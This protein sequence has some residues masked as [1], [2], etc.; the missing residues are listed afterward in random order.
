MVS[1]ERK[2]RTMSEELYRTWTEIDKRMFGDRY[3]AG[4]TAGDI[5]ASIPVADYLL[6]G[7]LGDI[8]VISRHHKKPF[9]PLA[10]VRSNARAKAKRKQKAKRA[11][12]RR[13]EQKSQAGGKKPATDLQRRTAVTRTIDG[14]TSPLKKRCAQNGVAAL[15]EA[16]NRRLAILAGAHNKNPEQIL[17]ALLRR[18][19]DEW[20]DGH[21]NLFVGR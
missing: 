4:E 21:S 14:A 2:K 3:E 10:E 18:E 20:S 9:T 17:T 7:A 13:A 15:S 1:D 5:A 19:V 11:K 12:E 8:G 16:Q 6:Y